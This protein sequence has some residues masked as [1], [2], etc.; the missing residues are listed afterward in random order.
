MTIKHLKTAKQALRLVLRATTEKLIA[1]HLKQMTDRAISPEYKVRIF[2]T[3]IS[4]HLEEILHSNVRTYRHQSS[5]K[6][7]RSHLSFLL[8]TLL[9]LH[10]ISITYIQSSSK[11][12]NGP[13]ILTRLIIGNRPKTII[14]RCK[15]NSKEEI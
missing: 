15:Y 5:S 13:N 4:I 6:P 11:K 14:I 8:A 1:V 10:S 9:L 2:L 12:V 3:Q 7:T